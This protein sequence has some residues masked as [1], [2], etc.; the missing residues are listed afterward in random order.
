M[1]LPHSSGCGG[2]AAPARPTDTS[3]I[4]S[5]APAV[6][7]LRVPSSQ[8]RPLRLTLSLHVGRLVP[9]PHLSGNSHRPVHFLFSRLI[10]STQL[11]CFLPNN[12]HSNRSIAYTNLNTG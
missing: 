12:L 2:A 9:S 3:R 10:D 7:L 8:I 11:T 1:E 6:A 5:G 4:H